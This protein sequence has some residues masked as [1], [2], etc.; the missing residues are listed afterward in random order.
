MKRVAL[1]LV[2]LFTAQAALAEARRND[3]VGRP[4]EL[5]DNLRDL[6]ARG[7][8]IAGSPEQ[9]R[10]RLDD[11]ALDV[12][13]VLTWLVPTALWPVFAR[14]YAA[15][16]PRPVTLKVNDKGIWKASE[17]SSLIVGVQPPAKTE[18]DDL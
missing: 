7:L 12:G 11:P 14:G 3:P 1:S 15:A 18:T 2:V 10:A 13:M 6:A 9:V 17:W 8:A 4:Y 16:S 5:D